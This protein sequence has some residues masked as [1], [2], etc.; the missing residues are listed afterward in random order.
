LIDQMYKRSHIRL[1]LLTLFLVLSP[2]SIMSQSDDTTSA[3][4]S[5]IHS[6]YTGLGYASNMIYLGSTMSG[7]PPKLQEQVQ[8]AGCIDYK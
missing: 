3:G 1:Y 2:V 8:D 6:F 5:S 7:R 4:E